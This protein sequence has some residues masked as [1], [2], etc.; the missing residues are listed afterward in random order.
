MIGLLSLLPH[1]KRRAPL[2]IAL[3]APPWYPVPPHGYGGIELVV[4]LLAHELTELG[5]EVT[6]F[7]RQSGGNRFEL[8]ALSP[9]GWTEDLGGREHLTRE[10]TYIRRAYEVVGR[11]PFDVVHDNSG[12]MGLVVASLLPL[13]SATVATLHGDLTAADA[14]FLSAIDRHVDLVAISRAQQGLVAG[15]RWAGMVHNAVDDRVLDFDPKGGEYLVELA[16]ICPEKGQHLAI[17]VA[18]RTGMRLILAGKI[19]EGSEA[20]FRKQVR[21]HL[22]DKVE[23]VENVAGRDK[24]KLLA[25]ARAMIFPIQWEEP[26]GLAMVE[27]MATGTPVVTTPRGAATEIVEEGVTGLFGDDVDG[28]VEAIHRVADIDRERCSEH[29][30]RRFSA[31]QMARGYEEIYR[32][33]ISAKR[34]RTGTF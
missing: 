17:E 8:L 28:L 15:V 10:A 26:F 20:Y 21:P 6:V 32:A 25:G 4:Y 14:E 16:R 3:I 5:H 30:R 23:W 13:Q 11:R 7:G 22:G 33:A 34:D 2:R 27:A 19:G 31:R 18:R 1:P 9:E 24:G 29:S 12:Y